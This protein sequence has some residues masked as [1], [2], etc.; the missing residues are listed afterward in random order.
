MHETG[1][2]YVKEIAAGVLNI[3]YVRVIP[4]GGHDRSAL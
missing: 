3:N 1:Q 4:Y 2:G